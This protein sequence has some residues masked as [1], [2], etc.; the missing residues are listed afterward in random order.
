MVEANDHR[1]IKTLVQK[2]GLY[3]KHIKL[4]ENETCKRTNF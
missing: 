1:K 3:M 2:V 4:K